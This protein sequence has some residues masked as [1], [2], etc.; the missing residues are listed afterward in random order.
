MVKNKS[1][2]CSSSQDGTGALRLLA[3][4]PYPCDE[5]GHRGHDVV[6]VAKNLRR[7]LERGLFPGRSRFLVVAPELRR[8]RNAD[9]ASDHDNTG[10]AQSVLPNLGHEAGPHRLKM[11]R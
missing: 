6:Q 1:I 11:R 3:W 9:D 7:K 5:F 8:V 2:L 4:V 10:E